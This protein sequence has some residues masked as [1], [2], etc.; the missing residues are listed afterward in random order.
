MGW[1]RRGGVSAARIAWTTAWTIA[2]ISTVGDG[3]RD[4]TFDGGAKDRKGG[5]WGAGIVRASE[6][7]SG[8]EEA[9]GEVCSHEG[10]G[11]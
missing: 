11:E 1:P 4:R 10:K 9:I 5:A 7:K 3:A 8:S 6:A 2:L